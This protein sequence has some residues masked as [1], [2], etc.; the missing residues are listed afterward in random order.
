MPTYGLLL[1]TTSFKHNYSSI[2]CIVLLCYMST[3]EYYSI[4][5]IT[6]FY[7][8]VC[9]RDDKEQHPNIITNHYILKELKPGLQEPS[10]CMHNFVLHIKVASPQCF[11]I[12]TFK[13]H[14]IGTYNQPS[15][16]LLLI[17]A[18]LT[19]FVEKV[20][21]HIHALHMQHESKYLQYQGK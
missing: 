3:H 17:F 20:L 8:T 5:I 21:S 4:H 18:G 14:S 9:F 1:A 15:V 19:H 11:S 7:Q 10:H 6:F 12:V 13:L 2:P 16:F